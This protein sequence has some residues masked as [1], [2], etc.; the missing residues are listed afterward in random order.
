ML[1]CL[2]IYTLNTLLQAQLRT[3]SQICWSELTKDTVPETDQLQGPRQQDNHLLVRTQGS[4][5]SATAQ[6]KQSEFPSCRWTVEGFPKGPALLTHLHAELAQSDSQAMPVV[7]FLFVSAFQPYMHHIRSWMYST[8][9]VASAF[10]E[11]PGADNT[12]C[13][14]LPGSTAVCLIACS[15]CVVLIA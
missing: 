13:P 6:N 5:S 15:S 4:D 3:L 14:Q 2:V 10:A 12:S 9:E 7:Q 8:A 1:S 11:V